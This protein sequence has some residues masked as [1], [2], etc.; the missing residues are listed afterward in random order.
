MLFIA[1]T[2]LRRTP[3]DEDTAA[4]LGMALENGK[5]P[6]DLIK[7]L[8]TAAGFLREKPGARLILTGGNPDPSGRTE[9]AVMRDLLTGYGIP[10]ERMI[11][12]D[13]A[14]STGENLANTAM[15][16]GTGSAI[17]VITS[18]YHMLRASL[19]AWDAGFTGTGRLPSPS[20]PAEY[21]AGIASETVLIIDRIIKKIAG[22]TV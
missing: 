8:E 17:T 12:E 1:G 3:G 21:M 5:P 13:R 19:T 6:Q 18:S 16:T 9:A 15:I 11:L 2:G 4:V 10:E 14:R 7:R 22:R 20:G